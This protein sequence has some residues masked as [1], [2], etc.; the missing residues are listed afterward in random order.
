[1]SRDINKQ[2][3]KDVYILDLCYFIFVQIFLNVI[4]LHVSMEHV[5]I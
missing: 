4:V 1:M 2:Q 3:Y 5:Q